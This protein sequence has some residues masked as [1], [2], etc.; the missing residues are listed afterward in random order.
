MKCKTVMRVVAAGLA[1]ALVG[2]GAASPAAAVTP[3][4]LRE[5]D[6]VMQ[7]R[8]E[9]AIALLERFAAEPDAAAL[10]VRRAL[11][12]RLR[13]AHLDLGDA[14]RAHQ[15]S[16]HLRDLGEARR[17]PVSLAYAALHDIDEHIRSYRTDAAKAELDRVS[18]LAGLAAPPDLRFAIHMLYGRLFLLKAEIER[19]IEQLQAGVR[20]AEHTEHPASARVEALSHLAYVYMQL[21][22]LSGAA[23]MVRQA[24]GADDG[25]LRVR[26]RAQLH[27]THALT[28]VYLGR[29]AEA[30]QEYGRAL[31]IARAGGIRVL[32]ARVLGDWADLALRREH[33]GAAERLGRDALRVSEAIGD[34]GAALT[35]RANIGFALGGQGRVKE[36]LTHIDPVIANFRKQGNHQAVLAML[37]EKG[38]MLE[39]QGWLREAVTLL[40]EQQKLERDQF[41]AQRGKAVASLQERFERDQARRRIELLQQLN[42]V[43][44]AELRNRALQQLALAL[45]VVLALAVG[46]LVGLL[47][48]RA[49]R[50]NAQLQAL[51]QRLAEHAVRD[52]LSRLYNRR[53]FIERMQARAARTEAERRSGAHGGDSFLLLDLDHFKSIND[54]WGHGAGDAVLVEVARRLQAAVRDSDTVLRWGG[55]EFLIHSS[56]GGEPGEALARRVLDAIGGAPIDTGTATLHVT[57]SAGM[58]DLPFAGLADEACGWQGALQL[59]DAALYVAKR[60]GRNRCCRVLAP[61]QPLSMTVAQIERDLAAAAAAGQVRLQMI[62]PSAP[63][64]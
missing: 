52:P 10:P 54:S 44:D 32:E 58:I 6:V 24:F 25:R 13:R 2:I 49:R 11:L 20:L 50:S 23:D 31:A 47:Y 34:S 29:A 7:T 22:D 48:R 42:R 51:N 41:T 43:K 56:G 57:A 19:A 8:P 55:E 9:R 33:F 63:A 14:A 18:H 60:A 3:P 38:R 5:A 64:A 61:Q 45:A 15:A 28:L 62:A 35:A 46:G 37:D 17:D 1:A 39:R 27:M 21:R 4:A 16:Q 40:R 53:F 36:G 12:V 59:A 30:E 26:L